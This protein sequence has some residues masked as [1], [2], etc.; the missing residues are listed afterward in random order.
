[1]ATS[2]AQPQLAIAPAGAGKTTAMRALTAA[3][4]EDGGTVLGLALSGEL[5]PDAVILGIVKEALAADR[6]AP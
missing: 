5:V 6:F 3:W 2:G 4:V 1:M